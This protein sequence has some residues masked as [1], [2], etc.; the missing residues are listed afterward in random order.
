MADRWHSLDKAQS[1][2]L[3]LTLLQM[4]QQLAHLDLGTGII[5]HGMVAECFRPIASLSALTCLKLNALAGEAGSM[6]EMFSGGPGSLQKLKVFSCSLYAEKDQL[7]GG[8]H[9]KGLYD[10][11]VM[12]AAC[13]NL[14]QLTLSSS[15]RDGIF[16]HGTAPSAAA[17]CRALRSLS[18]LTQLSLRAHRSWLDGMFDDFASLAQLQVLVIDG[19]SFSFDQDRAQAALTWP[20]LGKLTALTNLQEIDAKPLI[21]VTPQLPWSYPA[22][23]GAPAGPA[24]SQQDA[25]S[26]VGAGADSSRSSSEVGFR[27]AASTLPPGFALH[28]LL[29]EVAGSEPLQHHAAQLIKSHR[30]SG[31]VT[32]VDPGW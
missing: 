10:L 18:C 22:A 11:R 26:N 17:E 8:G 31:W 30:S 29:G 7:G 16:V 6:S 27:P 1:L 3:T 25:A 2:A 12:A 5:P 24:S 15:G 14:E 21:A 23:A 20:R 4:R 13:P 19:D 9:V 32:P 28:Q